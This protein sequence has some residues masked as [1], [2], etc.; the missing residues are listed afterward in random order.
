MITQKKITD[1]RV[2]YIGQKTNKKGIKSDFFIGYFN[3]VENGFTKHYFPNIRFDKIAFP[4]KLGDVFKTAVLEITDYT[5]D[6]N[7]FR[8]YNLIEVLK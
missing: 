6:N 1:L 7:L 2:L 8:V 4:V 3:E 5:F